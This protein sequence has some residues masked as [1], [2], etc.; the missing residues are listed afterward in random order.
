MCVCVFVCIYIYSRQRDGI[1]KPRNR[2]GCKV[3][4]T[5]T[6]RDRFFS[7]PQYLHLYARYTKSTNS[8]EDIIR[9]FSCMTD[10]DYITLE[11]KSI[12]FL[13]CNRRLLC[14]LGNKTDC[15]SADHCG[16][17]IAQTQTRA[18]CLNIWAIRVRAGIFL[19]VLPMQFYLDKWS[20]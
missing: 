8:C 2:V 19:K 1:L 9:T 11:T 4:N 16:P 17:L 20:T 5:S 15:C 7:Q 12:G 10:F 14:Y 18:R 6:S 13:T 3:A